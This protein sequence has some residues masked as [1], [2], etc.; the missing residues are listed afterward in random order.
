VRSGLLRYLLGPHRDGGREDWRKAHKE[1]LQSIHC[2]PNIIRVIASRRIRLAARA[3]YMGEKRN[4]YN[5]LMGKCGRNERR[6]RSRRIWEY[7][8][9][10]DFKGFGLIWLR[11]GT[12]IGLLTM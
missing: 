2:Y 5:T 7:N 11:T 6:G 12:S 3:V 9:Q 1:W 8:I 10:V 4:E